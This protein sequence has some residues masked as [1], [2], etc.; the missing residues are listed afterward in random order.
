MAYGQ[1]Y[2]VPEILM[3]SREG[4]AEREYINMC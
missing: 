1:T 2:I 3:P 4:G